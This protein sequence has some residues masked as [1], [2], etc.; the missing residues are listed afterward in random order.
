MSIKA[1]TKAFFKIKGINMTSY[2]TLKG[3]SKSNMHQ[4]LIKDKVYLKD[5]LEV[6]AEYNCKI[7]IIDNNSGRELITY[8]RYDIEDTDKQ[9]KDS[10]EVSYNDSVEIISVPIKVPVS[11]KDYYVPDIKEGAH[12]R[13]NN[14]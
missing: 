9:D 13:N 12:K 5:L 4:K 14:K 1:K 11:N 10:Q 7:A 3:T 2:A 8:N 6:C